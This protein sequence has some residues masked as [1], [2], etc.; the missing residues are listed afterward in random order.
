MRK[1]S[2][3]GALLALALASPS[4]RA[5]PIPVGEPPTPGVYNPTLGLAGDADASAVEKNPASLGYLPSWSGV[6]LHSE[7]DPAQHVGGRG[8]GFFVATPLPYLSAI[9]LGAAVQL[10]RP[11][12][13]FPYT[14]ETKFSLALGIR[15]HPGIAIGLHYAHLWAD[16]GPIAAGLDTLDLA[17]ALRP[18]RWL[19]AALVVHDLPSPAVQ[20]FPLQRVWE[21]ELAVRPLEDVARRDRRRRALRRAARRRRSALPPLARADAGPDHQSRRRVAPR[22]QP[23]RHRRER[24]ARRARRR[25]RPRARR[26]LRLRP[27]RH[28]LRRHARA[29]LHARRA[30]LRRSLPVG[31]AGPAAPRAPRSRRSSASASWRA[32]WRTCAAP[33]GCA[34][35]AGFV[36]VLGDVDGCV[37][38]RRGAA[39][40]ASSACAAP[41]STSSS[42]APRPTR[43]ATTSPPPPSA[44]SRIP[45]AA[46]ASSA[47]PR[48]RCSSGPRRS[49]RRAAPTSSK[50]PSTRAR[51][52]ST[53]APSSTPAGARAA[54]SL[55]RRR[56]GPPG[57][58]HRRRPPR[59]SD[60]PRA[61][62]SIAAPTPPRRPRPPASSTNCS[63]GDEVEAAITERLG[64]HVALKNPP[65]SPERER[66]W[67][68]PAVAVLFVDGDII[69]G[70]STNIPLLDMSFAGMQ[71][72]MPAIQRARDDAR[73]RPSSLRID[74][75]GGSALASD[76]SRASWSAP[77][78]SSRSSAR[79]ATSPPRA[80]TSSPP[81]ATRIFAAPSTLTGSI[82]I[83]TGKFDVSG[84]AAK[85]GV[86]LETL[87]A[88]RA[89]RHRV[90]LPPLHRRGARAD[91]GQAALLLRPLRRHGGARPRHDARR[92]STPS[93]AAT[94]GRARGA[95]PR[96]G[97][98]VRRAD[99]RHRRGQAARRPRRGRP[100]RRS[101]RM[102][103]EP[104][105]ARPAAR[106]PRHQRRRARRVTQS[107]RRAA[108]RA[109]RP[110][111]AR[112]PG[113]LLLAPSTPQ[114]RLD[115]DVTDSD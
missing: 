50:S 72:L 63:H 115:F 45:P 12:S 83:F 14:N 23:R 88:R 32:C 94:S 13:S 91:P 60:R 33:S 92:R 80:A 41:R 8:D 101:T 6:Y 73:V 57:R 79:S 114:A 47:C 104:S 24:R 25:A 52:S 11:P 17:L 61:P 107:E 46:S 68:R 49:A 85:L 27:L 62:G 65:S 29:R 38:H 97:R 112:L 76:C 109:D 67:E 78:R 16:R 81:P 39:R 18:S 58:R 10:L 110:R 5:Q 93:A 71:T 34:S 9:S 48:R 22:R 96:A 43:A 90:A 99:R 89:R 82:G 56:L 42:T 74:S 59:Q 1:A 64:R 86:S 113:S 55:R 15:L 84:L 54:R 28:R 111:S 20:G 51:P 2:L 37:G 36:L 87:R 75:P 3:V 103:D 21:P 19:A 105:A 106:A 26:H 7:L 95:A 40:R 98:R 4:A 108:A 31:V 44:S 69:D 70:K 66:D 30:H 53:R 77:R 102:P 35:V 100:R